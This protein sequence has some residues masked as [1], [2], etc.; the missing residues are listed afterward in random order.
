MPSLEELRKSGLIV[1]QVIAEKLE[2]DP[3]LVLEGTVTVDVDSARELVRWSGAK[4]MPPGF[5][6]ECLTEAARREAEPTHG[7]ARGR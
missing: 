6:A 1:Q 5:L 3:A 7:D 4:R 2:L